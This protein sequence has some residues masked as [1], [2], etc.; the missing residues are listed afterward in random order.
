VEDQLGEV[1]GVSRTRIR[2]V[3]H[4]LAREKVVTIAAQP[5]CAAVAHPTVREAKE[6]F[7]A[8]RLIEVALA[9]EI[10]RAVRPRTAVRSS[11]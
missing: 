9:P 2:W 10:I 7:A 1:F 8:R 3:L 4:S 5:R 6:V 11:G